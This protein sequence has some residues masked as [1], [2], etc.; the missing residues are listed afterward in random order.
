MVR[1]ALT[2]HLFC[3]KIS[4]VSKWTKLSFHLSLVAKEYYWVHPKWFLSLWYARRKPCTHL[5]SNWHYLQMDWIELPYEPRH[6]GVTLGVSKMI[7]EPMLRLAQTVHLFFST[8]TLSPNRPK[9]DSHDPRHLGFP[10][11]ASEMISE[12]M[13]HSTQIVHPSCVKIST[14]SKRTKLRFHLSLIIDEYHRG[15]PNWFW[16]YGTFGAKRATILR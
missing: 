9:R 14:I 8:Q 10:Y 4:T 15:R 11:G 1:S 12:P 3:D 5:A 6:L 2:E 7:T 13:V 16:A